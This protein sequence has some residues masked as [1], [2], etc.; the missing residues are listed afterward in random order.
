MYRVS[1][2]DDS[3]IGD[4][5]RLDFPSGIVFRTAMDVCLPHDHR[6]DQ[7]G[8]YRRMA[9]GCRLACSTEY[10]ES[11]HTPAVAIATV[12]PSSDVDFAVGAS[13]ALRIDGNLDGIRNARLFS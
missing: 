12:L 2:V 10:A 9:V 13:G 7:R 3:A 8:S 1:A 4:L 6:R 5:T 11:S